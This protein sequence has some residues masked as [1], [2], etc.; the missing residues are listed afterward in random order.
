MKG[1]YFDGL[2]I[3]DGPE[4]CAD[5]RDGV[6]EALDRGARRPAIE[7]RNRQV[8]GADAVENDGRQHRGRR[9]REPSAD[10]AGSENPCMRAISPC[11]RTGRSHGHPLVVMVGRVVR[12]RPKAVIP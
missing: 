4:P 11:S 5:A 2:A 9:F 6:G 3:H 10:P 12:G 8:R 7:P 1:S